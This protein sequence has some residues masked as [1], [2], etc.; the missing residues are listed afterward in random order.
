MNW[1]QMVNDLLDSGLTQTQLAELLRTSQ[2]QVSDMANGK[3]GQEITWRLGEAI[4]K[5]HRRI[6]KKAEAA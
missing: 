6:P 1:Q 2:G 4:R 5:A 3:R